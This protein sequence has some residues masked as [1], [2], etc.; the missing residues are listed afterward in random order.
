M[1][2][3]LGKKKINGGMI[4]ACLLSRYVLYESINQTVQ[5]AYYSRYTVAKVNEVYGSSYYVQKIHYVFT[6]NGLKFENGANKNNVVLGKSYYVKYSYLN[7]EYSSLM[8][9]FVV[10][11]SIIAPE[12]GWEQLPE[13]YQP[14]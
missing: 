4:A 14:N 5:L 12:N 2:F 6:A 9:D 13:N 8:D 1:Q 3:F 10:P 11:D 7:P